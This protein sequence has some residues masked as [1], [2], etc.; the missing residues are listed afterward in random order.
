M[1]LGTRVQARRSGQ[2]FLWFA[3]A[4]SAL[5]TV[6]VLYPLLIVGQDLFVRDGN[7][8]T[9]AFQEA[10]HEPNILPVIAQTVALVLGSTVMATCIAVL[11]AWLNERTDARMGKLTDDL[12]V[13]PL[14]VPPIAGSI[15]WILLASPQAGYLNVA[16][17]DGLSLFGVELQEGPFD[18]STWYGLL[19][20]YVLYQMPYVYVVVS[21]GL[22]NLDPAYEEAA[23]TFGSSN[24][25][26]LVRVTI[27]AVKP[28]ILGGAFLALVIGF[29]LFSVPAI[30]GTQAGIEVLSVRMVRLVTVT[31]P[32][33]TD[34][35]IVLGIVVLAALAAT[36]LVQRRIV[37]S[38]HFAAVGGR[39]SRSSRIRLHKW[40]VV[41]RASII[42]YIL[43]TLVL[44][45]VALLLVSL[46][47]YWSAEIRWASFDLR[48]YVEVLVGDGT[49][50]HALVNSILY[51]V[52]AAT[53]AMLVAMVVAVRQHFR[54]GGLI[55]LSADAA[56]KVSGAIS[57]VI[58]AIAILVAFARPPFLLHGTAAILILAYVVMYMPQASVTAQTA[59][60]QIGR[61]MTEAAQV[62]GARYGRI[63]ARI[64]TPLSLSGLAGGWA[65]VF[66]LAAGDITGSVVLSSVNT[67]VA[68][69][70]LLQ[71]WE[72]GRYPKLAAFAIII[73]I[74]SSVV[75]LAVMAVARRLNF[76][77]RALRKQERPTNVNAARS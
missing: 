76:A 61:D 77:S 1:N 72:S 9:A 5:L 75:V 62:N 64:L 43:A 39:G 63:V 36:W 71:I 28:S 58:L 57:H 52:I 47:T 20:V 3:T 53:L 11:F 23:R 6:A 26:T 7:L 15:G 30:I 49:T 32:P 48:Q 2:K 69:S 4:V 60:A 24:L 68:G 66:V 10:W 42:S 16:I 46:Q 56:G 74:L 35:A 44:P 40:R 18:I 13:I 25:R 70:M 41:A 33:R 59:V 51:A 27:P 65:L 14:L 38:G 55:N 29:A 54:P 22:R 37:D 17:R 45:V 73:S 12:P 19:F 8:S 31:Y 34:V 50:R 21:A 67:P